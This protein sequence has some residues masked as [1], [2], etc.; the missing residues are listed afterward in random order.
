MLECNGNVLHASDGFSIALSE[1][2]QMVQIALGVKSAQRRRGVDI[3][4]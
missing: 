1:L 4:G 2:Q 3:N